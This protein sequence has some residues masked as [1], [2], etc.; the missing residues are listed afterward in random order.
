M[1]LS[2]KKIEFAL[3][4]DGKAKFPMPPSFVLR[5]VLGS[6]LRRMCCVARAAMTQ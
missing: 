3:S 2:Y 5:S 4:F 6:Q 1:K